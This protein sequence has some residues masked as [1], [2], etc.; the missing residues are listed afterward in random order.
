MDH[1]DRPPSFKAYFSSDIDGFRNISAYIACI[2]CDLPIRPRIGRRSYAVPMRKM[3][4]KMAEHLLR[5]VL[6][7]ELKNKFGP[8]ETCFSKLQYLIYSRNQF[9][10]F[11]Y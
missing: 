10:I 6:V 11:I 7:A 8:P 1:A 4:G 5:C 3:A 2:L 9:I